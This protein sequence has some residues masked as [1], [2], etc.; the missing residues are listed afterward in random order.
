MVDRAGFVALIGAPNAG[1]STLLNHLVGQKLS[2]V[3]HKVQTTRAL[4]RGV[5]MAGDA[6]IIFIDTPGIFQPKRRLDRAM[7]HAAWSGAADADVVALLIDAARGVT[8][9]VRAIIDGLKSSNRPAVLLLNKIDLVRRADLLPLAEALNAEGVFSD[10]FMISAEKG[11]GV[12]DL[13]TFLAGRMPEGPHLY[14]PD[15]LTDLSSRLLAA[16]ITRE[17]LFHHL[18]QELPYHLTVETE[19]Y[20]E[21]KDGSVKLDQ[22]I[23]V[24]RKGHKGIV[25][26]KGGETIKRIGKQ[27]REDIATLLGCKVH[28]FLFVK[29]REKWE[30]DP[31]RYAPWG[32]NPDAKG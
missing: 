2:I 5:V 12:A 31:N 7:V 25:L 9:E 23:Y 17:K 4:L 3:C 11:E 16:E 10:I 28:L 1:K 22:T 14:P 8:D 15:Q 32:L 30:D 13:K 29:V 6:Q 20:E 24:T 27:A 18:H 21:R 26:G 19:T